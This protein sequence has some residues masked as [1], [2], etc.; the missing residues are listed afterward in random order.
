MPCRK[1]LND[2]RGDVVALERHVAVRSKKRNGVAK[3][4]CSVSREGVR[5]RRESW[6]S[7]LCNSHAIQWRKGYRERGMSI[8]DFIGSG[9]PTPH[10]AFE[11]CLVVGCDRQRAAGRTRLC[12]AHRAQFHRANPSG[13]PE[14]EWARHATPILARGSFSL[15]GLSEPL[16]SEMLL[17]L[18]E[19]D[20]AS[21]GIDPVTTAIVVRVLSQLGTSLVESGFELHALKLGS[22]LPKKAMTFIARA[23]WTINRLRSRCFGIDPT[24]GDVWDTLLVGLST[25]GRGGRPRTESQVKYSSKR[26]AVDFTVI[27]QKWLRELVKQWARDLLPTTNALLSRVRAFAILSEVLDRRIDGDDPNTA[28][29]RDILLTIEAVNRLKKP[30]GRPY[31]AVIRSNHLTGIRETLQ[32][33]RAAGFMDDVPAGFAVLTTDRVRRT[34]PAD[35][36]PGKALPYRVVAALSRALPDLPEGP[37]QAGAIIEGS[38]LVLLHR[39]ALRTLIDTGRRASEVCSLRVGCVIR[40]V[41]PGTGGASTEYTLVYDN[42][43]AGRDGRLLPITRETAEALLEWEAIRKTLTLPPVF[44]EWLF[45]TPSVGR[46]DARGHLTVPGLARALKQLVRTVPHFEDDVPDRQSGGYLEFRGPIHSGSFRHS[47]AQRHADVGVEPD[48][49]RELMDHKSISTTMGYYKVSTKRKRQAIE[50]VSPMSVDWKGNLA[51]VTSITAYEVGSVAVPWGNCTEPSNVKAGGHACPI[52]FRCSGCS[53]YRPDPS[54]LPGI[55]EHV[56]QLRAT[57]TMVELAGTAAPWVLQA[58]RDEI[59]GYDEI[60]KAMKAQ[61]AALP[62]EEQAAVE[63]ASTALRKVRAQRRMIPLTVIRRDDNG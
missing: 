17:A 55:Q 26:V 12:T 7:G 50:K 15:N 33:L 25:A 62:A 36:A 48:T 59:A 51:P 6:T 28:G 4:I 9:I 57:L 41:S 46:K 43:K 60:I 53:M 3:T 29:S 10:P 22:H 18:Q 34:R 37:G 35:E 24:A 13:N 52:R 5:C 2:H 40:S 1:F 30:D 38:Q 49:L 14:D 42:H 56:T 11:I 8:V 39:A 45:P 16:R 19:D 63:D 23:T 20:R 27:H 21:Y 61:I 32:Y 31:S 44:D 47:Y 54:F 58:A